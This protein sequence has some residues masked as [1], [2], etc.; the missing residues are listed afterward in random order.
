M[1]RDMTDWPWHDEPKT[2]TN[3]PPTPRGAPHQD[4][5]KWWWMSILSFSGNST[6]CFI[7]DEWGDEVA[8][9]NG[10]ESMARHIVEVHNKAIGAPLTPIVARLPE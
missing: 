3:L 8:T 4:E 2:G 10:G 5:Q 6:V 1:L 9:T 7:I